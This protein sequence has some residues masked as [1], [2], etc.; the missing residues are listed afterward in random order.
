M[1]S[2]IPSL[3]LDGWIDNKHLQIRKI[4]EY[5]MTSEYSQT[6]TFIGDICS[7][8]YILAT[9]IPEVNLVSNVEAALRRMYSKY[10]DNV[11]VDVILDQ[12]TDI[13]KYILKISISCV[14]DDQT[15]Y[16]NR[17]LAYSNGKIDR[18]E[19][20]LDELYGYYGIK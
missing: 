14:D 10:F 2:S 3:T 19:N 1:K 6:N 12:D 9:S 4:W 5:F 8:K 11:N 7:L 13:T 20:L 18:Y 16:L 17:E 15:Y